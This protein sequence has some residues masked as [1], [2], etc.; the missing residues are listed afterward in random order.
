MSFKGHATTGSTDAYMPPAGNHPA[1]QIAVLDLGVHER[2]F[3]DPKTRTERRYW[4][5]RGLLGWQLLIPETGVLFKEFAFGE[6]HGPKSGL[7]LL[8]EKLRGKPYRPGEELDPREMLGHPCLVTVVHRTSTKGATYAKIDSINPVPEGMTVPAATLAPLVWDVAEGKPWPAVPWLLS[9][10]YSEPIADVL[11]RARKEK[12]AVSPSA[13]GAT[14]A[15][16]PSTNGT[17]Q[18]NAPATPASPATYNPPF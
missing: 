8:M 14:L 16:A 1:R 2:T 15:S 11:A 7:R 18:A 3:H 13:N 10:L 5:N 12:P 9:R 4:E 17:A 6:E